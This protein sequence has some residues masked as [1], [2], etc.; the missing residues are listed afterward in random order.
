M[1]SITL[2]NSCQPQG[3]CDV[4]VLICLSMD[5]IITIYVVTSVNNVEQPLLDATHIEFNCY[6]KSFKEI[7]Q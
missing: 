2:Y 1:E 6:T 7:V 4:V 5:L 3:S